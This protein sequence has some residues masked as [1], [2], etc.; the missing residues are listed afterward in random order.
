[1]NVIRF[2]KYKGGKH[3][4]VTM[5]YD[6]AKEA[7][8]RLVEI[9]NLHG[10]KGT[11]HIN[12][13][14][15]GM[16]NI[17]PPE[18]LSK[19]YEG[20][21]MAIHGVNHLTLPYLPAHD[22]VKEV[23]N[24]RSEIEKLAGYVVRGMSYPNGAYSDEVVSAARAGGIKYART[25]DCSG[26]FRQPEDFMRW[27]PTCHHNDAISY[28]ERLVK[29]SYYTGH[30][31]YIYGH[32]YEFDKNNNWSLI[33]NVCDILSG[34][35]RIWFATNG[36]LYDYITA[37][38]STEVSADDKIIRNPSATDVWFSCENETLC[39]KAGE[40]LYL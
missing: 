1:M 23:L 25:I 40:T 16:E 13:G 39:V 34:D 26:N 17:I 37:C 35:E 27:N 4:A 3:R 18:K 8:F 15:F 32:S 22:M 9:F 28:A 31:L 38:R 12:S 36:E 7:D 19:L 14:R 29:M 5:S 30:L 33:E 10:V 2:D 21:E 24:D 6:D 11:F 20:H